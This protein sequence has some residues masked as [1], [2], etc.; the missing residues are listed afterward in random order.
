VTDTGSPLYGEAT[1]PFGLLESNTFTSILLRIVIGQTTLE[2]ELLNGGFLNGC[3]LVGYVF[4]RMIIDRSS[5][6]FTTSSQRLLYRLDSRHENET[7]FAEQRDD[8]AG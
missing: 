8:K 3:L 4:E 1:T 6:N 2:R 5:S 7:C